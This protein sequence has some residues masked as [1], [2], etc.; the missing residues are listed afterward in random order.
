LSE[1]LKFD[2]MKK[3]ALIILCCVIVFVSC[4]KKTTTPII[5]TE[6]VTSISQTSATAG[7]TITSDGS[8]EVTS[9]GVCWGT[10]PDPTIANLKS[11][12]G[13]GTGSFVCEIPGLVAGT[14]YHLRAFATNKMG[15]GYGSDVEFK[16]ADEALTG[17]DGN[18]DTNDKT[19]IEGQTY[20]DNTASMWAGIS[21]ERSKPKNLLFR[22]NSI[23]SINSEGYMLQAGDERPG[24]TN[25][26][27]DG[28]NI[29]GNKF[30]WNGTNVAGTITHGIFTGYNINVLIEYNY[31]LKVPLGIALKS[32][33]MTNKSGG[34]FYNIINQTG[35]KAIAVKGINGS[36]IYNNTFYSNEVKFTDKS[37][38]GTA[39]ALIEIYANDGI[40][41]KPDSK[42]TKIKNNI[43]YTVN[44]IFN[45][46]IE[47]QADLAGFESDYNLFW[48]EKGTPV[49]QYLGAQKTFAE[50]Q[51]LGFDKHSVVVNPNFTNL[52]DFV[53]AARLDYGT[54]L[55]TEFMK[56]LSTSAGWIVGS[57]PATNDQNGHWQVG[58]RV[59]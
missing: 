42:G 46:S 44:Q 27:L 58:A 45:I 8:S 17:G 33:G 5:V 19:I 57:S 2:R 52:T 9:R 40:A 54:D 23:T 53:P 14:V 13:S 21:I 28:E 6:A 25:N 18:V 38:P 49:F 29:S 24:D 3:L 7:G 12:N 51:A 36:R 39:E 37:K 43:F 32:N 47:T 26:N 31:L 16:T 35:N 50:W 10:S 59:F 34:V 20:T 11:I 15:T 56:G 41:G 4:K 48:C 30:V 55:G 1:G 22:N